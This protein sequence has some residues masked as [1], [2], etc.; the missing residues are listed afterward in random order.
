MVVARR[1]RMPPGRFAPARLLR[2]APTRSAPLGAT[3]VLDHASPPDRLGRTAALG[4]GRGLRDEPRPTL[5]PGRRS[6]VAL[7]VDRSV[8]RGRGQRGASANPSP[9][10]RTGL[11]TTT[12][13]FLRPSST[14]P[15]TLTS[16]PS[17]SPSTH[18]PLSL[19]TRRGVMPPRHALLGV[20]ARSTLTPVLAHSPAMNTAVLGHLRRAVFD[21]APGWLGSSTSTVLRQAAHECHDGCRRPEPA[22][23]GPPQT[24]RVPVS[25]RTAAYCSRTPGVDTAE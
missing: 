19:R 1:G 5:G 20:S 6:R 14:T 4:G 18:T 7:Q 3:L 10:R 12:A 9:T 8:I 22:R 17:Q 24:G 2:G 16:K 11:P 21:P 23:A 15:T 13:T 25:S